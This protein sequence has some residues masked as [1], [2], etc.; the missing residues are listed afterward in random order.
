MARDPSRKQINITTTQ[1]LFDQV[2]DICARLD[3]PV[4][5]WVRELIKRELNNP[6]ITS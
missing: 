3:V 1:E 4:T 5:V 6:T 2:K